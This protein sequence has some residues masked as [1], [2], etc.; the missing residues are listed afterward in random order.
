[1][2]SAALRILPI[3]IFVSVT[4][5][6]ADCFAQLLGQKIADGQEVEVHRQGQTRRG[7]VSGY[8][9]GEYRV[10]YGDGPFDSEWVREADVIVVARQ[11]D[12]RPAEF[13]TAPLY[14]AIGA[15]MCPA[16]LVVLAILY[17]LGVF[18]RKPPPPQLP[19]VRYPPQ[20]F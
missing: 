2:F 15:A 13:D 8:M 7:V 3:L 5:T 9:A 16:T 20:R 14:Q 19:P 17:F 11:P 1:M 10:K 12:A 18:N 4:L 6:G